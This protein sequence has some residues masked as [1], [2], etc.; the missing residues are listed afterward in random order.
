MTIAVPTT[1]G[2]AAAAATHS[3]GPQVTVYKIK[4][5]SDYGFTPNVGDTDIHGTLLYPTSGILGPSGYFVTINGDGTVTDNLSI[6]LDDTIGDFAMGNIGFYLPDDTLFA[7]MSFDTARPK[8]KSVGSTAGN[9]LEIIAKM[10]FGYNSPTLDYTTITGAVATRAELADPGL[11]TP[12]STAPAN[13]IKMALQ[14]E[15]NRAIVVDEATA[16]DWTSMNYD[17]KV[18]SS[19]VVYAGGV[20][21]ISSVQITDMFSAGASVVSGRYLLRFTSGTLRGRVRALVPFPARAASTYYELNQFVVPAS[22]NGHQ[23]QVTVAGTTSA[24]GPPTYPTNGTTVT[25]GGVTF[26]EAGVA[27]YNA[28]AWTVSTGS[29]ASPGDT[30][31]IFR[32]SSFTDLDKYITEYRM[33]LRGRAYFVQHH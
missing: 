8:T 14:D 9:S 26:E 25:D 18:L 10:G 28:C 15:F 32:A 19:G 22:P 12:P 20:L 17:W 30:F 29:A 2:I 31:D 4:I 16:H 13:T 1:V 27:Y 24:G 21:G 3:G 23:Y 6:I 7:L 5:G 11:L 33:R